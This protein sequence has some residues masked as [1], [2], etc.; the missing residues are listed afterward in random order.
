MPYDVYASPVPV[1]EARRST[2]IGLRFDTEAQALERACFL[3]RAGWHVY[4]LKGPDG[5]EMSEAD[6]ESYCKA[7]DRT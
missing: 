2:M 7:P 5:V 1:P 6:I 3:R 4:R